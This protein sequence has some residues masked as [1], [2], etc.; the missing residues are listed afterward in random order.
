MNTLDIIGR[1]QPLFQNDLLKYEKEMD[2]IIRESRFLV[3]GGA[4]SIGQA[5]TKQLFARCA[6]LL[7]VVDLSENYLVELVRDIRS[8]LGYVTKS[9]DTFAIDCGS[10]Y[11]NDFLAVGEY[12]YVLNLSAMKHVRSENSAFSMLR[13]LEANVLNPISNY[14]A[15]VESG[16]KKYFCVSTDKAANPA[17]FMG[18]TKRAMEIALMRSNTDVPVSGARFAN[19]A[20]SNGS[21]LHGFE[22]RLAKKQPLS[23]PINIERFFITSEESGII[24]L[25]AAILGGRNEILFPYNERE[26]KL[27]TF[28]DIA[29]HY[30]AS[31]GL[32]GIE[33][34]SE[35][36]ARDFIKS[37]DLSKNWPINVF[38][39]DTVGEKPF[40]EFFTS[41]EMLMYNK[42][43]DLASVKFTSE[44]SIEDIKTLKYKILSVNPANPRARQ[45]YLDMIHEFVPTFKYVTADKFLNSRM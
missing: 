30:L 11:F 36:E 3:I 21:L 1:Q 24:C 20:F 15:A 25:F 19:V 44:A 42:F 17:N 5:V 10:P 12:D 43:Y 35:Q 33:C 7:H 39:S 32:N 27:R 34:K 9:F 38:L 14:D 37:E 31:R 2:S 29:K 18:A 45:Q 8:E 6:K 23:T 16:V 22:N 26:L 40:E 28:L 13:M 4:G 41:N